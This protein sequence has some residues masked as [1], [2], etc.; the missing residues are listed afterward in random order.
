MARHRSS[1]CPGMAGGEGL[2][3][4]RRSVERRTA[5]P[6]SGDTA[7][8]SRAM[9]RAAS[10]PWRCHRP[11]ERAQ[12]ILAEPAPFRDYHGR[13][14]QNRLPGK[15]LVKARCGPGG[16]H[17]AGP[18]PGAGLASDARLR[19]AEPGSPGQLRQGCSCGVPAADDDRAMHARLE[20][21]MRPLPPVRTKE[22]PAVVGS[23][24]ERDAH[25]SGLGKV[26]P[27]VRPG[28]RTPGIPARQGVQ[29]D[30]E[31][32]VG[33]GADS[34]RCDPGVRCARSPEVLQLSGR[35]VGDHADRDRWAGDPP[36]RLPL[37]A[38]RQPPPSRRGW[39]GGAGRMQAGWAFRRRP[40]PSVA[41]APLPGPMPGEAADG[42]APGPDLPGETVE[43]SFFQ[44]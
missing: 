8:M 1:L 23:A 9:A 44:E 12:P 16:R 29:Q 4:P 35:R 33:S 34:G 39:P 32:G 26:L 38:P 5:A 20:H 14:R 28:R 19:D 21:G 17:S 36:P 40:N 24:V 25:T 7:P 10:S 30:H 22:L 27:P 43:E 6:W 3:G 31:D 11:G 2:G 15:G 37:G 42:T 13:G 18:F 41:T